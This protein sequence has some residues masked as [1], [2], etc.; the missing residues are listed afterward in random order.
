MQDT[1]RN[2]V[3][4][5]AIILDPPRA[6]TTKEFIE[7]AAKLSPDKIWYISC[8]PRTQVRD[9]LQFRRLGYT[10]KTM[11]LVDMFPN[12]KHIETLVLLTRDKKQLF[13]KNKAV[14]PKRS[15]RRISR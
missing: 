5:D 8:D 13:S 10:T 14:S 7:A 6:G 3:H 1:T 4:Y 12:T 11:E 2:H 9:L 15:T